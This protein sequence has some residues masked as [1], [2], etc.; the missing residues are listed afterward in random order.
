VAADP[1]RIAANYL[2][3]AAAIASI[4]SGL[5]LDP[6]VL[7]SFAHRNDDFFKCFY[8]VS[9]DVNLDDLPF[10]SD[11]MQES[12]DRW[13]GML[14]LSPSGATA[15]GEAMKK[16]RFTEEWISY[17]LRQAKTALAA[18]ESRLRV[19]LTSPRNFVTVQK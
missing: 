7:V 18:V 9:H 17:I 5:H 10:I 8:H 2:I 19:D 1:M 14:M 16:S 15:L 4:E 13:N 11:L 6:V 3:D 12:V